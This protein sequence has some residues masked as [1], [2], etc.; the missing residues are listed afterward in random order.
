MYCNYAEGVR[1]LGMLRSYEG[2]RHAKITRQDMITVAHWLG[3]YNIIDYDLTIH[4]YSRD[5]V[6]RLE[7]HDLR[8]DQQ[9]IV[10]YDPTDDMVLDW[11]QLID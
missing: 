6:R 2:A 8:L 10:D 5:D 9:W 4:S 7:F 11:L 1:L 3:V